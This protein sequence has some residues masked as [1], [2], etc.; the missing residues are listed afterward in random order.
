MIRQ[1]HSYLAGAVSATALVSLAVVAFVVL[2]S[3]QALRDWPL[4]GLATGADKGATSTGAPDGGQTT[5]SGTAG[6][7]PSPTQ[8]AAANPRGN[9]TAPLAETGAEE[10][11]AAKPAAGGPSGGG[12]AGSAPAPSSSGNAQPATSTAPSRSGSQTPSEEG[13][14][15]SVGT[16]V[17]DTVS[18]AGQAVDETVSG[19]G[20]A[21][22][23]VVGGAG[24]SSSPIGRVTGQVTEVTDALLGSD[25]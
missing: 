4:A 11:Q 6:A 2:V 22:E 20:Q 12:G 21:V 17:E 24:D 10:A 25:R 1:A 9:G 16:A 19:A 15:S 14:P 13:P 8:A 5:F 18:S 7:G 3:L 23:G